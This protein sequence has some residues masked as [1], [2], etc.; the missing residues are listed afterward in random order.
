MT[1]GSIMPCPVGTYQPAVV[2]AT[3]CLLCPTGSKTTATASIQATDCNVTLPGWYM[4]GSAT[5]G[6]TNSNGSALI[7]F[8]SSTPMAYMFDRCP[9][10]TYN[11]GGNLA[12][13]CTACPYGTTTRY[14]HGMGYYW[15]YNGVDNTE[16]MCVPVAEHLPT[17]NVSTGGQSYEAYSTFSASG[18]RYLWRWGAGP[19][20][21]DNRLL[22]TSLKE[23]EFD[24]ALLGGHLPSLHSLS[25]AEHLLGVHNRL[26]PRNSGWY[27]RTDLWL[28]FFAHLDSAARGPTRFRP[29][30]KTGSG[31]TR[32]TCRSRWRRLQ[33][34]ARV[35][36]ATGQRPT[37]LAC[38]PGTWV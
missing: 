16:D 38:C 26:W 30:I 23:A 10:N 32:V 31:G 24:C 8:N 4:S 33:G 5:N 27:S 6:T 12:T 2:A 35:H 11:N 18:T 21:S 14:D 25:Q 9:V 17:V 28:G 20:S 13:A 7:G 22:R 1:A 3:Q 19:G 36:G 15:Y 37:T 34:A 29:G